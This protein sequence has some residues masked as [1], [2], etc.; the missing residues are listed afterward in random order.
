MGG[1]RGN[2]KPPE[3]DKTRVPTGD[4]RERSE[5]SCWCMQ[6]QTLR[7][8]W[9]RGREKRRRKE[10]EKRVK[11][12]TRKWEG[13]GEQKCQIFFQPVVSGL[14]GRRQSCPACL[15][16]THASIRW[17][18]ARRSKEYRSRAERMKKTT[19]H[20]ASKRFMVICFCFFLVKS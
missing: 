15:C 12:D 3:H 4:T 20:M 16:W 18:Q 6:G 19:D 7:Q 2:R 10:R 17:R 13:N 14:Q 9:V 5:K 11:V 8:C 1:K